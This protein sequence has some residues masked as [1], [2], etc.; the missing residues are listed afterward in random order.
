MARGDFSNFSNYFS[1]EKDNM[2]WDDVTYLHI[3][4]NE[5]NDF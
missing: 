2:V 5:I 4:K 1:V 3:E